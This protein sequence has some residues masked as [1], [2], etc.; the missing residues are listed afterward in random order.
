M[1]V[2]MEICRIENQATSTNP[3]KY[4]FKLS[5]IGLIYEIE[6]LQKKIREALD[7]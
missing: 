7:K 5:A 4:E 1:N 3:T 6:M 2:K